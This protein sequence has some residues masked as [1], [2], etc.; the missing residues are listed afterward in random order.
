MRAGQFTGAIPFDAGTIISLH[1][2]N[3]DDAPFQLVVIKWRHQGISR[4]LAHNLVL[5]LK[6]S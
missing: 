1:P 3:P 4:T 2:S 5:H 6:A